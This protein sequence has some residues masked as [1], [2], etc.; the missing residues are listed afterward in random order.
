MGTT[1]TRSH[2][3]VCIGESM[4][5]HPGVDPQI[6]HD[7]LGHF[8]NTAIQRQSRQIIAAQRREP[9]QLRRMLPHDGLTNP[10]DYPFDR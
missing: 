1:A 8:R 10:E 6:A 3:V 2:R 5:E 9:I 7:G 4:I